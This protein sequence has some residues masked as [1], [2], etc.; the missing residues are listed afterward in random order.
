MIRHYRRQQVGKHW[1]NCEVLGRVGTYCDYYHQGHLSS[2]HQ[3]PK[4]FFSLKNNG[5][6]VTHSD[7]FLAY[8]TFINNCNNHIILSICKK[9]WY[10]ERTQRETRLFSILQF[11]G[12]FGGVNRTLHLASFGSKST[13]SF[14]KEDFVSFSCWVAIGW[15]RWLRTGQGKGGWRWHSL[16]RAEETRHGKT[17]L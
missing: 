15:M 11:Q 8:T 17:V 7:Q 4:Y 13:S 10:N 12:G 14:A 16:I 2:N 5:V 3:S 6:S 1:E 9:T